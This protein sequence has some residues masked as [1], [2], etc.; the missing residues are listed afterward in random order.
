MPKIKNWPASERPRER[1]LEKGAQSL[2]DAELLAVLLRNGVP[3][4]DATQLARELL[5]EF[6]GLRGFLHAS[7]R[8][9]LQKE[10]LGP[11]KV[12]SI[13]ASVEIIR[14][15]MRGELLGKNV[16]REPSAV[17]DYLYASLRD[18]PKEI[19]KVIYL[20]KANRVLSDE[21]L[22]H[23]TVDQSLVH[24][25]EVVRSALE[26]H[27]TSVILVHNHPSG[28]VEPSIEDRQVTGRIQTALATCSITVLDH[29]IIGD[30]RYFSFR[31]QG[32][33]R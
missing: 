22:F 14:R 29:L 28:R 6:G 15:Q 8:E 7:P 27:A 24:P 23:G 1:L 18:E 33:L 21:D 9:L 12:A 17:V 10:G 25:R 31:E 30:N 2:S 16:V 26:R 19:F 20:D 5:T 11:A 4:K 13:A 32:L 3:G